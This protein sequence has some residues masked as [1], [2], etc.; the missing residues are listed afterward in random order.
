LKVF[1][2]KGRGAEPPEVKAA[3]LEE[4]LKLIKEGK[5]KTAYKVFGRVILEVPLE[6]AERTIRA[7][8]EELKKRLEGG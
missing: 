4:A 3:E 8:L 6:E 2:P 5:A 1:G 7:E